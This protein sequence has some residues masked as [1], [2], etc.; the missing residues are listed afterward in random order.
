MES[1]NEDVNSIDTAIT[2]CGNNVKGHREIANRFFFFILVSTLFFVS[3]QLFTFWY[4]RQD[5]MEVTAMY[6][7]M[8]KDL[9]NYKQLYDYQERDT[10]KTNKDASDAMLRHAYI[11]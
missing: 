1:K 10:L 6:S 9:V 5:K 3:L 8:R 2:V 4:N 7:Q 11:K